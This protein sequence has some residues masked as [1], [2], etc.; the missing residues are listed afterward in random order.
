M[1]PATTAGCDIATAC[2]ASI[3]TVLRAGAPCHR[4]LGVRMDHLV[5]GCDRLREFYLAV[6][7]ELAPYLLVVRAAP[8]D[9]TRC[10]SGRAIGSSCSRR[11]VSSPS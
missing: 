2:D 4:S 11:P 8:A 10:D 6:A 5:S 7:P 1:T 9:P 3:S